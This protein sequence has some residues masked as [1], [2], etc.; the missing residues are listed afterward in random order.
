LA[1]PIAL[2]VAPENDQQHTFDWEGTPAPDPAR[3]PQ[4]AVG[5]PRR[6]TP[7]LLLG[8]LGAAALVAALVVVL[9]GGGGGTQNS[10]VVLASDTTTHAPGYKFALT[11]NV[12][13]AGHDVSLSGS[14]AI[15]NGP[16]LSGTSTV[17]VGGVS[18]SERIVGSDVYVQTPS[19]GEK[20][21]RISLSGLPGFAD[22]S[23]S[24]QYTSTDPAAMLAYLRASGTVIDEGPETLGG[25]ATTHYHAVV[26]L[27]RYA[28]S[29]SA[30]QQAGLQSYE[31]LTGSSTF[32][33][34][35]WIDGSNLVREIDLDLSLDVQ[36]VQVSVT[37]SMSFS[38]FGPQAAVS[39][40]PASQVTDLPGQT[41]AQT[42][43]APDPGSSQ[44][45]D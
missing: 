29:L 4:P 44:P 20:W 2:R 1:Q 9:A 11:V 22:T 31:Q 16:P 39:A 35:V 8:G 25:V 14:G 30:A 38:D 15:N 18:V 3:P 6:V 26:D 17:T 24:S 21:G 13:T 40:P 37:Y 41:P 45:A 27:A 43:T 32:P 42:P 33:I 12:N 5:P 28:A 23:S 36:S 10:R 7:R 19:M 34:D